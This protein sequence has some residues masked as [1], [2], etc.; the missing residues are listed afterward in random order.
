LATATKAFKSARSLR[1]IA[2]FCSIS[3][4]QDSA[5]AFTCLVN[6][7]VIGRAQT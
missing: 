1:F 2:E 6:M 3:S 4:S 5:F 7:W